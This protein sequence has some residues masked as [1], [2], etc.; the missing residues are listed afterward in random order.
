MIVAKIVKVHACIT[1]VLFA[2][3]RVARPS[4]FVRLCVV[5]LSVREIIAN[6]NVGRRFAYRRCYSMS[7]RA[8]VLNSASCGRRIGNKTNDCLFGQTVRWLANTVTFRDAEFNS[9]G[10]IYVFLPSTKLTNGY[11]H[12]RWQTKFP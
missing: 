11:S 6:P 7:E 5:M 10:F 8:F 12:E 4:P 9:L 2:T 1:S 3:M